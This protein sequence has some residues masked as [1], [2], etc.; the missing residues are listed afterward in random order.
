LVIETGHNKVIAVEIKKSSSPT[1]SKGFHIACDDIHASK[2]F[3]VY[4]GEDSFSM[5]NDVTAISL[6]GMMELLLEMEK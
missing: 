5:G 2:K 6:K 3:V 4:S 1:I